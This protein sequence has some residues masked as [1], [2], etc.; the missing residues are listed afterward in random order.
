MGWNSAT[1]IMDV[2]LKAAE[3]VVR[4]GMNEATGGTPMAWPRTQVDDI[5]RPFVRTLAAYLRGE[6]WDAIEE[7]EFFDRFAQ[8]MLGHGNVDHEEWL[9]C[10]TI[11]S[12]AD[13]AWTERLTEHRMRMV[14]RGHVVTPRRES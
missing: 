3:T 10:K 5:L 1:E 11:S 8:E 13:P 6:D 12:R 2:A 4:T 14:E 7:S 9:I